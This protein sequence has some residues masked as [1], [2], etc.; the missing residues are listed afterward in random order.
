M[1]RRQFI[2]KS[3]LVSSAIVLPNLLTGC[4]FDNE[5]GLGVA[6]VGLGQYST[7]QLAPALQK[8][9]NCYLA[10][11]VS[12]T[13][14]KKND[15]SKKYKIREENIYSYD[16]FDQI[17]GNDEIDVVYVAL[18]NALHKEFVIRSAKAGKHVICEK[19]MGISSTECKEMIDACEQNNVLLS[20]GY[21]LHFDNYHRHVMSLSKKSRLRQINADFGYVVEDPNEWR[22]KKE[23]AGGGALMNIGIYC[24]QS[25]CYISNQLPEMVTAQS[26]KSKPHF[27][28]E[29]EETITFQFSFPDAISNTFSTS[30][31]YPA[32]RL[33]VDS[34]N[35]KFDLSPAFT[36][37]GLGSTFRSRKFST[38]NQQAL[39]LDD[40]CKCIIEGRRS[41]VSGEMGLR[42]LQIIEAIYEAAELKKE[43]KINYS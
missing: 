43:V 36:Y 32:N 10:G 26:F 40:F 24:V 14:E 1:D 18:P 19:P 7:D 25:A 16:S 15:W 21:R 34:E 9:N 17:K 8:T 30:H 38:V 6:L 29:V 28:T 27:F 42:D 41:K 23:L 20:V 33:S 13:D 31:N 5:V 3:T 39:Q 22:M 2:E 4:R 35:E 37:S 11:I 12:G